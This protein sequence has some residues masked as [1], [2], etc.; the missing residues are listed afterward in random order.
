[1]KLC[2]GNS[3]FRR[4]A[5]LGMTAVIHVASASMGYGQNGK[6]SAT[7]DKREFDVASVREDPP[8]GASRSNFS[9]DNGNVFSVVEK[10]DVFTPAGTL[11]SAANQSLLTY[12]NF[13][14]GLTGT[15][16]L[17]LRFKEYVG[18]SGNVPGW[19]GSKRFTIEARTPSEVTKDQMRA[20]LRSLLE[21]RFH[22]VTRWETRQVPVSGLVLAEPG[23]LGSHLRQ[24][25]ADDSCTETEGLA[26]GLPQTCGVI[27]RLP[28]T[29]PGRSHF[30]GR[31]VT[32]ALLASSFPTQT[33]MMLLPHPVIDQTGLTG[34][35]DFDLE[36]LAEVLPSGEPLPT[37][38]TGPSFQEALKK[39][40]GFKLVPGRGPVEV[41]VIDHVDLPTAN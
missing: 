20:M 41:L 34:T 17:S 38:A 32:M 5:C 19:M 16:Y 18:G 15:Q 9:L 14:Y 21:D 31:N 26:P 12:I 13:A 40:L 36:Y 4:L 11:F 2:S 25:P 23:K 6:L 22:L 3:R 24:H 39:Q 29:G 8:G 33:G 27:A 37:D 7:A 28:P 1:M 35:Y 30:G 10:K